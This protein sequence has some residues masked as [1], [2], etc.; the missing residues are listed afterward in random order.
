MSQPVAKVVD[1]TD[2]ALTR[3]RGV[4]LEDARARVARGDAEA[5]AELDGSYAL[6]GVDGIAVR[7]A[8]SMDRPLRYF[9]AKEAAGPVLVVAD[10]IDAIARWLAEN[11]HADQFHPSYTRM[12][13][14]HHLATVRLVGCPDPE[15]SY[16]RTFTPERNALPE[17]VD[18]IGLLYVS[19]L[20]DEIAGWLERVPAHE[21]LGIC[22]SGGIDSGAVFLVTHHV[23]LKLGM[24]PARL[25]AF[26]LTCEEGPD[27]AQARTFLDA[28]GM[29]FFLESVDVDAASLDPFEAVRV[30]ED[31]KPLDVE[32]ATMAI[33]LL[34]GASAPATRTGG[35]SSTATAGTRTSRTT[36]SRRTPS[37]RSG[38][39]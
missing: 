18:A 21:P 11:G 13:P 17:D 36:R 24:S 32:S 1:L 7:L 22:F 37:S 9:L 4:S 30:I 5:V 20:A 25:K 34:R 12:V 27:L 38:A 31:Y 23:L 14:A 28:C 19:A 26:T 2:A 3:L 10:R 35:S 29:G 39:S 16:V 15:P 33:A 8:R 6:V